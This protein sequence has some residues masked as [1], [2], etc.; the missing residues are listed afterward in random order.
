[1]S[2]TVGSE[3]LC[4][5]DQFD[6]VIG[7]RT[8]SE[9]HALG[10]R[11]RAV[12]LLIFDAGGRLFLQKRSNIKDINPGLWDSS[13]AGHVDAGE[14]YDACVLRELR[15]ELG[16]GLVHVPELLFRLPAIPETGMEFCQV[17]RLEHPGPFDLNA[18]EISEGHWYAPEKLDAWVVS[19]EGITTTFR[20]IWRKFRELENNRLIME[21]RR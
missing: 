1:M 10:L 18:E 17:Y 20:L 14:T 11:H 19:G 16:I 2:D 21:S 7:L 9:I 3:V 5:V 4:V 8:R 6:D 15:E 13:A 12:H